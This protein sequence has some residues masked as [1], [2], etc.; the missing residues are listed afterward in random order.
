MFASSSVTEHLLR[1]LFG[2]T[3]LVVAFVVV[4]RE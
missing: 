4:T 2:F 1:G 3:A